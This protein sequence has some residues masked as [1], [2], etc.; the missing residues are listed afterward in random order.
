VTSHE[1]IAIARRAV[2]ITSRKETFEDD[3]VELKSKWPE[4]DFE[5]ARQVAAQ[6]N[7]RGGQEFVWLIGIRQKKGVV[8]A[9]AKDGSEWLPV[10]RTYFDEGVMPKLSLH[11]N[12][13]IEGKQ[14]VAL[15]W[16]S[17]EPPYVLNRDGNGRCP[18]W[19]PWREGGSV[20]SADRRELLRI[21]EPL[22]LAPALEFVP[23]ARS[24]IAANVFVGGSGLQWKLM[25]WVRVI[26]RSAK[27]VVIRYG[28][29]TGRLLLEGSVDPIPL[30]LL[31]YTNDGE[32][33]N[34]QTGS[35]EVTFT[36]P[37]TIGLIGPDLQNPLPLIDRPKRL[38]SEITFQAIGASETARVIT[39]WSEP[40]SGR[41][42]S[43]GFWVP[44]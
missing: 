26:P 19:V 20:R 35:G 37:A 24:Y 40:P 17:H 28:G 44:E 1:L 9:P 23:H 16:E 27:P 11:E 31:M 41:G 18:A 33:P 13:D 29:T 8:G 2:E 43:W 32:T 34:R 5:M 6:A 36:A 14:V 42:Q 12:L 4:S 3:R 21:L 39:F 15:G 38:Q 25:C 22:A 30:T 10:L 7:T